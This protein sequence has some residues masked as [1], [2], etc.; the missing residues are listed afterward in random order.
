VKN[1]RKNRK[2]CKLSLK[3]QLQSAINDGILASY[4]VTAL[5]IVNGQ[6]RAAVSI[7]P[8]SYAK[9]IIADWCFKCS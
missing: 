8:V 1:N 5:N 6:P 4:K 3:K 7:V 9:E 2:K